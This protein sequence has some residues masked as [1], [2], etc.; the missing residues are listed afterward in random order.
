VWGHL[1]WQIVTNIFGA[2]WRLIQGTK[3]SLN[4]RYPGTTMMSVSSYP[5]GQMNTA[6]RSIKVKSCHCCV[7]AVC[8]SRSSIAGQWRSKRMTVRDAVWERVRWNSWHCS[9]T[10]SSGKWRPQRARHKKPT[11]RSRTLLDK[12][13]SS[14]LLKKLSVFYGIRKFITLFNRQPLVPILSKMN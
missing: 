11:P 1:V 13:T 5:E 8:W 14:H 3:F 4:R 6:L 2:T 12:S 9:S 10:G 7:A